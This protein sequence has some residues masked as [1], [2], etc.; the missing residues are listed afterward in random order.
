MIYLNIGS[1]LKSIYG[2]RF[3]NIILSIK[4]LKKHNIKVKKVSS[5]YETPSYPNKKNPKFINISIKIQ[6]DLKPLELLKIIKSIEKKIGRSK[7]K[8][9]RPRVCDIDIID[10]K[11]LKINKS[12]IQ[13]P[14]P[15]LHLR[16]FV[17]F[18][19]KE[20]EPKWTHPKFNKKID[21][22]VNELNSTLCMEITRLKKNVTI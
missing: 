15:R 1:N 5:F 18:P 16:N 7:D 9:N 20:I 13:L 17:L 14:H 2:N 4:L 10:F 21:L 19:L 11:K 8:R 3:K 6:S 12:N 22:L